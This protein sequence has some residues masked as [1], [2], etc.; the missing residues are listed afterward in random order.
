VSRA[1]EDS[2]PAL[3]VALL[4]D[5]VVVRS[6]GD[7]VE[8][9][10]RVDD[11]LRAIDGEREDRLR[12]EKI[13]TSCRDPDCPFAAHFW[14]RFR[15]RDAVEIRFDREEFAIRT[16]AWLRRLDHEQLVELCGI[17]ARL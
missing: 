9:F 13:L 6:E 12:V 2:A 15:D 4:E 8:L 10:A 1:E 14:L 16:L 11:L 7:P 3:V 17:E 5:A